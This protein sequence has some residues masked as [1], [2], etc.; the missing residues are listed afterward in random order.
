MYS[1]VA[2]SKAEPENLNAV[3]DIF[4]GQLVPEIS[5]QEGLRVAYY[6][7]KPTG[8]ILIFQIWEK[9]E[10]FKAWCKTPAHD[11]IEAEVA[12]LR[13]GK[14]MVEGYQLRAHMVVDAMQ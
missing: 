8:E 4:R 7:S 14:L 11:A 6:M 10:N 12:T 13:Q 5:K 2:S 1:I 9:E 3:I